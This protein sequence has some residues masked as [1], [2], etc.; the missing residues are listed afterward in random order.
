MFTRFVSLNELWAK[1]IVEELIRN[2][3][4]F[5][6]LSPGSRSSPLTAAVAA[7]ND[8]AS[9]VHYDERGAAFHGLGYARA[10]RL[11]TALICTSGTAAANFMPAVVEAEMDMVP[12]I[13]LTADRPPELR[14]TGANQTI[15][16]VHLYGR[17]AR[18]FCDL[19]CPDLDIVPEF[20]LTTIDQAVHYARRT[21]AGPVHINCMFREPLVPVGEKSDFSNYL[22]P[23]ARWTQ[24]SEPFTQYVATETV[25]D[26]ES[27]LQVAKAINSVERGLLVV[28]QLHRRENRQ[29]VADLAQQIKWPVLPDIASGLRLSADNQNVMAYYDQLLLSDTFT[30]VNR[31][32]AVLHFGGVPTSKRLQQFLKA[33]QPEIYIHVANHPRRHDPDHRIT[34][35]IESS[36]AAFC[37]KLGGRLNPGA[38]SEW[39]EKWVAGS[40]CVEQV[41][42]TRLD[43]VSELSEPGIARLVSKYILPGSGL[44][45]AS[46]MPIRDLDMYAD[47][48][49]PE[50]TVGCNRGASGIDGTIASAI[51]FARGLNRPTTLLIGDLAFLHDLN[52]LALIKSLRHSFTIVV[53]NNDGGGIFSFLPTAKLKEH[54]EPFFG[55]PHG[56][57]FKPAAQ[58]FGCDHGCPNSCESFVEAYESAQQKDG[59]TIIEVSSNREKNRRFHQDIQSELAGSLNKP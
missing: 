27:I 30:A 39:L 2:G 37:R 36:I 58:M 7:H 46:S 38:G 19:P 22:T 34:M 52:S 23:V 20:V 59:V 17:Y 6:V 40:R 45:V 25:T 57:D 56:L 47:P 24:D 49:G 14:H 44:F 1:L 12:L 11:P 3:V 8:A 13:L 32:Q 51:G 21:P 5:F 28:G 55:T 41:L 35:R 31:P 18:W 50:V 43:A 53:L 16:Q 26:K 9:V 54:F 15:D 42:E 10:T 48:S 33:C 29:A 4:S